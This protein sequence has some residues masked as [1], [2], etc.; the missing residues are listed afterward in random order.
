MAPVIRPAK[1]ADAAQLGEVHVAA[2]RWA[3]RGLMP[4]EVLDSLRPEARAKAWES[5]LDEHEGGFQAWVA[6][7]DGR[8]VGFAS[9]GVSRDDDLPDDSV[10][11]FAIYLLEPYLHTGI[12]ARLLDAAE[13]AWI[14]DGKQL[15]ALWVLETNTGTIEFYERHGWNHDGGRRHHPVAPEVTMPVVR[16]TKKLLG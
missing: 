4:D 15:G 12:G 6:E 1:I 2:W 13:A 7:V 8:V 5:W 16:Y 9:S 11:L 3:Y 10:E 14:E